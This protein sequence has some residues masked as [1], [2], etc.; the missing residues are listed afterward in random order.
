MKM[1]KGPSTDTV[2][3]SVDPVQLVSWLAGRLIVMAK[4][5]LGMSGVT[6]VAQVIWNV[7][8]S[9]W[10]FLVIVHLTGE[11]DLNGLIR[12]LKSKYLIWQCKRNNYRVSDLFEL[13]VK[14]HPDKLCLLNEEGSWTFAQVDDYANRVANCFSE[15][16]FRPGEEVAIFMEGRPEYV[17]IW[18]GLSKIGVIPALVNTN[19]RL[20]PLAHS[21]TVVNS[22]AVIF[23]SELLEAIRDV[24]PLIKE[25][26]NIKFFCVGNFDAASLPVQSLDLLLQDSSTDKPCNGH[27]GCYTDRLFYVYTSGTTGLPKAAIITHSRFIW[28]GSAIHNMLK[29]RDDDVIYTC[30][31]LY[32]TAAGILSVCQVFVFGNTLAIRRKFSASKFWEDCIKYNATVS[33]YIGEIC[34]YLLASPYSSQEKQHKVRLMFGNGLRKEIWQQFVDRFDIKQIGELYGSTEGNANVINLDN[35]VG[36]VGFI[37]RIAPSVYPVSLI[38]MNPDTEEPVRDQN[39]LCIICKPGEPG[40]FVGKILHTDPIRSFDGYVNKSATQKKVIQDVFRKGDCAFLSGDLLIMDK[41]GYLYFVDRTGDTFRW[42]G[43]N[44]ST[45]EVEGII[46]KVL[47]MA[48]CVVYGVDVPGMEGKAG[49]IALPESPEV[50]AMDHKKFLVDL[51]KSLPPYAVPLFIRIVDQL[52]QTGTYKF[53]KVD[54]QKEGFNPKV[55]SDVMYY[56]NPTEATYKI[57]DISAYEDICLAKIRL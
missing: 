5:V 25:T 4:T 55:V 56:M 27:K 34:R 45:S 47:G 41:K 21:I 11:R 12:L 23:G 43:E 13:K 8:K 22:K 18:L 46:S 20:D 30:L 48:D 24:T 17:A 32:H 28:M 38:K 39:G 1:E 40:E 2:Q 15:L 7:L 16:G 50:K 42:K 36:S 9:I 52:E 6:Y 10:D 54:L 14:Q 33:Q 3:S 37:S 35:K 49:M 51:R 44:V 26:S 53:K 19:Q 57:L 29:V 31:P